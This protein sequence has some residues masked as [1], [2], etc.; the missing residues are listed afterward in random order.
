MK[1][2]HEESVTTRNAW[3]AN[4]DTRIAELQGRRPPVQPV[5]APLPRRLKLADHKEKA[6]HEASLME[7]DETKNAANAEI[8]TAMEKYKIELAKVQDTY[9]MYLTYCSIT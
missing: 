6:D 7:W 8:A 5:R 4:E 9:N 3:K 2:E 1:R